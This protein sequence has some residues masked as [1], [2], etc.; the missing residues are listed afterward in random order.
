MTGYPEIVRPLKDR[1]GLTWAEIGEAV[2]N[3]IAEKMV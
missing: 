2:E 1:Q 3:Y